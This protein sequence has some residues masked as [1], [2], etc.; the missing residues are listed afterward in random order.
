MA[1]TYMIGN[2]KMNQSLEEVKSFFTS[3]KEQNLS[4]GNFWI[5]PQL[6]H[7]TTSLEIAGNIKIGSQNV[8]H[9]GNGAFTGETSAV[10]LK[11]LGVHFSLVGHSERRALYGETDQSVNLKTKKILEVGLVP[12][13]CIGETLEERESGKTLDV[14]LSQIKNGLQDIKLTSESQLILAYEPV[15]AIGTGK[16][17]SPEQ[18]EEVHAA[19]RKLLNELYPSIGQEMSILYGGSVK[20]AN[21]A[22][23]LSMPNI[24][25]GL[26][27]GAS[28]KADSFSDLCRA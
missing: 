21:V 5:A 10:S 14:V 8:S 27:G 26:V 18:A 25:G 22:S 13:V 28:I 20:P 12:V 3:L 16:T 4:Q 17:A 9:Q 1:K 11:E 15:W 7:I 24:N 19:I 6:I 23:L 2:W